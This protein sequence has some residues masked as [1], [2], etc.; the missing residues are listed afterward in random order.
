[1]IKKN[2]LESGHRG[3]IHQ[4]NK[5]V[6]YD[7]PTANIMLNGENLNAFLLRSGTT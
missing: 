5:K 4:H 6:M 3:N 2:F 7:K 1:M